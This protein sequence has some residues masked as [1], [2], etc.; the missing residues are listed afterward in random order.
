MKTY[1]AYN[2]WHTTTSW[3]PI[4]S[5]YELDR[6]MRERIIEEFKKLE[7]LFK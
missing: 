7:D 1:Y 4:V 5:Q 3:G 6:R 2:Y